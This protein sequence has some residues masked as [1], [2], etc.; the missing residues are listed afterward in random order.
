[1][2][3]SMEATEIGTGPDRG[4][5]FRDVAALLAELAT[6]V[7]DRELPGGITRETRLMAELGCE[8]IDIVM[9]IVE[10]HKHFRRQA[11]PWDDLLMPGGG[12]VGDVRAGEIADFLHAHL[13]GSGRMA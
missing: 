2:E 12:Y 13:S 9:L 5:V 4:E 3:L 8:S 10:I 11:F 6:T 7:W 1:K